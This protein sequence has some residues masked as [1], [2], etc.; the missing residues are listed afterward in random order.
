MI[1]GMSFKPKIVSFEL[2]LAFPQVAERCLEAPVLS[3]GYEFNFVR[4]TQMDL[5]CS[6]WLDRNSMKSSLTGLLSGDV[7]SGD[8][9]ARRC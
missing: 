4:G 6:S 5:A 1:R 8:V 9:I 3:S 7:G 2:N